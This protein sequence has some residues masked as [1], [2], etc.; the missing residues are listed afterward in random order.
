MKSTGGS[1]SVVQH[2]NG[3]ISISSNGSNASDNIS[4]PTQRYIESM[5]PMIRRQK[6]LFRTVHELQKQ[7]AIKSSIDQH[8]TF[9]GDN[10]TNLRK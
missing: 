8:Q 9:S 7:S 4:S 6:D 2:S 1:S 3:G 10:R 5:N